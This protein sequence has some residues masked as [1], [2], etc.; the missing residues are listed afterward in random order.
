MR[1]HLIRLS[2]IMGIIFSAGTLSGCDAIK[3]FLAGCSSERVGDSTDVK[4]GK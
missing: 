3:D 1:T 2:L 4:C